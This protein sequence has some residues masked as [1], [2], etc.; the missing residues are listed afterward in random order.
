MGED[1]KM[2]KVVAGKPEGKRTLGSPRHEWEVRSEWTLGRLGW[3][4]GVD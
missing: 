2:Y 4:C 1:R 3:G